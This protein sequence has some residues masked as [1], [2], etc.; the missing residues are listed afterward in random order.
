[1]NKELQPRLMMLVGLPGSGKSTFIKEFL[2]SREADIVVVSTDD[3]IQRKADAEGITYNQAFN[4][5]VKKASTNMKAM[6]KDAVEEKK[7]IIWDQTN[8]TPKSRKKKLKMIPADIYF[9]EAVVF[10]IPDHVIEER[11]KK[12]EEVEGK[13]IPSHIMD[14][15]RESFLI[16]TREEG[17]DKVTKMEK[18]I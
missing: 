1:M 4:K 5:Y 6:L 9:R 17:F 10:D 16:P 12:R 11:L 2:E 8:L 18:V 7:D 3:Y 14:R 13:S 15:M